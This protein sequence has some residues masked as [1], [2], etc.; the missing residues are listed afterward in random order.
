MEEKKK[1]P[2][3]SPDGHA[4][5]R[6]SFKD[7]Q[8]WLKDSRPNVGDDILNTCRYT[9]TEYGRECARKSL[10]FLLCLCRVRDSVVALS[11]V[12]VLWKEV[13]EGL[14]KVSNAAGMVLVERMR[15][16]Y[17]EDLEDRLDG[18]GLLHVEAPCEIWARAEYLDVGVRSALAIM[19]AYGLPL[20][21]GTEKKPVPFFP[22][23]SERGFFSQDADGRV[24][25][26]DEA[27]IHSISASMAFMQEWLRLGQLIARTPMSTPRLSDEL[28]NFGQ[29]FSW[30]GFMLEGN[31]RS[32]HFEGQ[33]E[34]Q[35]CVNVFF[36]ADALRRILPD[37]IPSR[38]R[39]RKG[40]KPLV[41][42]R[43][44]QTLEKWP[45]DLKDV[46][47]LFFGLAQGD[48]DGMPTDVDVPESGPVS[49][50]ESEIGQEMFLSMA[51]SLKNL[52][53]EMQNDIRKYRSYSF[54]KD[55]ERWVED[56]IKSVTQHGWEGDEI[57]T[58]RL[59][60]FTGLRQAFSSIR[61]LSGR[62]ALVCEMMDAWIEFGRPIFPACCGC[63]GFIECLGPEFTA[64]AFVLDVREHLK[65]DPRVKSEELYYGCSLPSP[66]SS[67]VDNLVDVLQMHGVIGKDI[68]PDRL[69]GWTMPIRELMRINEAIMSVQD[70][71]EVFRN[72]ADFSKLPEDWAKLFR[73]KTGNRG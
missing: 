71:P 36:T 72:A 45:D 9:D 20:L 15:R 73:R 53:E 13:W 49:E 58:G 27:E 57:L 52:L 29:E 37:R 70:G 32:P 38:D 55:I 51:D 7:I 3:I 48:E 40:F 14:N 4:T 65:T 2:K 69:H 47:D 31:Y 26:K 10:Y 19:T 33:D 42:A 22:D 17:L 64:S 8:E 61:S 44:S 21:A 50:D 16:L 41:D 11:D 60:F 56:E 12:R 24:L 43:N 46:R 5:G 66:I 30:A 35:L 39:I 63:E 25:S 67:K 54:P 62:C 6:I 68:S 23:F 59:R 34:E 1:K 28:L 18:E